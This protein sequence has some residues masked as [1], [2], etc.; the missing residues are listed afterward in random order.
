[1]RIISKINRISGPPSGGSNFNM[2]IRILDIRNLNIEEISK[3][4]SEERLKKA[5]KYKYDADRVRAIAAHYLL[6]DMIEQLN[7]NIKTPV[8][9]VV[10]SHG[11]PH[12]YD[13]NEK[14]LFEFSLSHSGD[15][16][17]CIISDKKCGIDIERV[18]ERPFEKIAARVCHEDELKDINGDVKR[19][20]DYWTLKESILKAVGLGLSLDMRSFK[21]I[22][23]NNESGRY[24]CNVNSQKYN[25]E[26]LEAP[27]GYSLSYV[28]LAE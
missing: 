22:R 1:M 18:S 27:D 9:P 2:I 6:N 23:E 14:D 25:G 26:V 5:E 24:T 28:E 15:Y 11:K 10:D 3:K 20:Y 7:I 12:I 21:L 16:V 13:E 17:A 19:F 4:V 8:S